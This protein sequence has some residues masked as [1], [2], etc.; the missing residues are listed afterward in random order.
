MLFYTE[1]W[2]IRL[3]L[4]MVIEKREILQMHVVKTMA[5]FSNSQTAI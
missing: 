3:A 2:A 5:V 4:D 1:L